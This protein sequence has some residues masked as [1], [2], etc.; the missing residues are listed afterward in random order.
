M[1]RRFVRHLAKLGC[2]LV[3]ALAIFL[4]S[5]QTACAQFP[6]YGGGGMTFGFP[7]WGYG[8]L[9]GWPAMGYGYGGLGYGYGGL[10]YAGVGYPGLGYGYG[11]LGYG[12]GGPGYGGV[13]PGFG[14]PAY[15]GFGFGNPGFYTPGLFNPLFGVG[16]T[17]LGAQS[18]MMETQLF[19]RRR[20]R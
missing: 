2:A 7:G 6:A 17:P 1:L 3:L 13:Y 16:L 20:A 11:G 19:G 18:Y 14:Y 4:V 15:Y 8:G 9:Y 12:Y 10:G 5:S